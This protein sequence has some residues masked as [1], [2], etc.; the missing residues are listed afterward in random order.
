MQLAQ[1]TVWPEQNSHPPLD[2]TRL[3]GR[4]IATII[5]CCL[6]PAD[7]RRDSPNRSCN[8]FFKSKLSEISPIGRLLSAVLIK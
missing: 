3:I 8:G 7:R 5:V 1:L 2:K 6:L 4:T